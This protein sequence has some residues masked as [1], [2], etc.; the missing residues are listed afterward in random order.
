MIFSVKSAKLSFSCLVLRTCSAA[1]LSAVFTTAACRRRRDNEC[2]P[3]CC[4]ETPLV[5]TKSTWKWW[6]F[7]RPSCRLQPHPNHPKSGEIGEKSG[8][9]APKSPPKVLFERIF[10]TF[11]SSFPIFSLWKFHVL[12]RVPLKDFTCAFCKSFVIK[13]HPD[14]RKFARVR[15][16]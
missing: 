5:D 8:K 1:S 2:L 4:F 11:S 9:S 15:N 13:F 3:T 10:S 6:L 16:T 12:R 7:S 14:C